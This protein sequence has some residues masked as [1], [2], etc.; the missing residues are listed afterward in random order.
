[1]NVKQFLSSFN[2]IVS[3]PDGVEKLKEI[4]F[5]LAA[6]GAL[7]SDD[8]GV[9][10]RPLLDSIREQKAIHPE[11]RKV[12]P[13]QTKLSPSE[14]R[15]PKHWA[16]CRIGDLVLTIT[17][18]GTPSKSNPAYWG[19]DIPWASVKDLRDEKYLKETEDFITRDG[20]LNSSTNL[21]PPGRVIVSTRMGLGKIVIN[22]IET[23]INQ[24][25]KALE[26]PVEV[27]SDFFYILYRT[28]II[29]GT[30]TTVSGIKQR[31]LM[32][33]PAA[34]PS[35]EEQKQIVEKTNELTVLCDK[36]KA[37]QKE[38]T[39][40]AKLARSA[41]LNALSN[42][43][44][45]MELEVALSRVNAHMEIILDDVES[46]ADLEK[47]L[48]KLAVQGLLHISTDES[49]SL[50]KI[51]EACLT[52]KSEYRENGWLRT[53]K[54]I[55]PSTY[56]MNV[57]PSHWGVLPLDEVVVITGGI[58]K[59]HK[60]KGKEVRSFQ[61][62]SVANVQR[63]FFDLTSVK[64]IN[65]PV[66]HVDKYSL[67]SGDLLITEGGDWDKVGRTAIWKGEIRDCL[68][69]NH[70]FKAR[71]SSPLLMKE[72]VELVL[73]SAVGRDYFAGASKQTTNL[74]SI[75]MTQL[76][77]FPL[78]I[79]PTS[80]QIEIVQ[81]VKYLISIIQKLKAQ[82]QALN[83][84]ATMLSSAAVKSITGVQTEVQSK[85]KVPKTELV[86]NLRIG[87]S[88]ANSE[89]AA[90]AAILIR[91]NGELSAKNLWQASGLEIDAFYQK[92]KTEMARGWIVQPEPAD[93]REVE[94]S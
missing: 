8:S 14:V 31:Q 30:G 74:A 35:I 68:H 11:Q 47:C 71:S 28:R 61:Y 83:D 18:G 65:V 54:S 87:V 34:L 12:V 63:G 9:D 33:L 43:E 20:L 32:A 26:L 4:S 2:Y 42:A 37:Q 52:L 79:P 6:T 67:E 81:K 13:P 16:P 62:L 46:L 51:K 90:L 3:L 55:S 56:D 58:T 27:D 1:M 88:P 48:I 75:N 69:Q 60:L 76:R 53:R 66:E 91:N 7:L 25:L 10:A 41:T 78:P 19:G 64:Y 15:A 72:W 84:V 45:S 5:F 86:S 73:N 89:R 40:L 77:K 17:G 29:K 50:G 22:E 44:N 38:R 23:T 93:V 80:E 57:Y 70:V 24:D 59:G 92:L 21:I 39:R 85:M 36:L 82:Q 49:P 94:A